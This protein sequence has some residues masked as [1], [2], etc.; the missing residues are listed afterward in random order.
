[1]RLITILSGFL[2]FSFTVTSV[3]QLNTKVAYE[4]NFSDLPVHNEI[5]QEYN[6]TQV[7]LETPLKDLLFL[8]G[9]QLGFRYSLDNLSLEFTWGNL[10]NR[11]TAEGT[12]PLE[13]TA[14]SR[15]LKYNFSRYSF[16]LEN[17]IGKVGIGG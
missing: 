2:F 10:F 11:R 1:M 5:L 15:K 8:N 17:R 13:E 4:A 6:E 3:A 12:A 14:F 7:G 9:L 16:G